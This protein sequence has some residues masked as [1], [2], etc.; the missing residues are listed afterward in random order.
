MKLL[1]WDTSSK[2]ASLV[3]IEWGEDP[4]ITLGAHEPFRLV[5]ELT[6]NVDLNHSE[7]LLWGVHQVLESAR[8]KLHQVDYWGVGVGPGSFTGLRIG[9]TTARTLGHFLKKPVVSFSSLSALARPVALHASGGSSSPVLIVAATDACKGE[10]FA[11]WGSAPEI[12]QGS[13]SE[14]VLPPSLLVG[15]LKKKLSALGRNSK[16]MVVGEARTRYSEVWEELPE[17]KRLLDRSFF[18]DQIQGRYAGLLSFEAVQAGRL[19][20]GLQVSPVY[21]RASDAEVKLKAGLLKPAPIGNL[22][23][24]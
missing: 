20:E 5:A 12:L 10:L 22:S 13:Y 14:E 17:S 11:L 16:W 23:E 4:K 2:T 21:L 9:V 15:R 7:R 8:W 1:A 6:L 18:S 3:A 19:L 24:V